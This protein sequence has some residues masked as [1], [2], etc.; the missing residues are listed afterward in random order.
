MDN[1]IRTIIITDHG[2]YSPRPGGHPWNGQP[3][4]KKDGWGLLRRS[5]LQV[6][7]GSRGENPCWKFVVEL[8][9]YR[10]EPENPGRAAPKVPLG[11]ARQEERDEW[12]RSSHGAR[13]RD[14]GR[15]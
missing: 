7:T 5:P 13:T 2:N 1:L 3:C 14:P 10:T 6:S 4:P 11:E 8:G 9:D 15:Y 12:Q